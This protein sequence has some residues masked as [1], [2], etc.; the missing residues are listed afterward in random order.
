MLSE[1]FR[2]VWRASKNFSICWILMPPSCLSETLSSIEAIEKEIEQASAGQVVT[3]KLKELQTAPTP[4]PL[5]TAKEGE[6]WFPHLWKL[7]L[8]IVRLQPWG[9]HPIG[10]PQPP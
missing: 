3:G 4:H 8:G 10:G 6:L 1:I 7:P 5:K 2:A 9:V